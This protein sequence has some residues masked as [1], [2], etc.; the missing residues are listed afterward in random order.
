MILWYGGHL[1][2]HIEFHP[3]C[4]WSRLSTQVFFYLP[5]GILSGSRVKMRGHLIAHGTSL[6]RSAPGLNDVFRIIMTGVPESI[7]LMQLCLESIAHVLVRLTA[8]VIKCFSSQFLIPH[9]VEDGCDEVCFVHC[10]CWVCFSSRFKREWLS[11]KTIFFFFDPF[12]FTGRLPT[13]ELHGN[14][15]PLFLSLTHSAACRNIPYYFLF[16][17]NPLTFSIHL[18]FCRPPIPVFPV[19]TSRMHS[20]FYIVC[21]CHDLSLYYSSQICKFFQLVTISP[22]LF[23]CSCMHCFSYGHYCSLF[24]YWSSDSFSFWYHKLRLSHPVSSGLQW[25][26]YGRRWRQSPPGAPR[27]LTAIFYILFN[28]NILSRFVALMYFVMNEKILR[29]F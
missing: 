21:L 14:F 8:N 16:A 3:F 6:S 22:V 19:Q 12:V 18:L 26:N 5:R 10:V 20:Q 24:L 25:R 11:L 27:V 28:Y 4:P 7:V 17:V 2:R 9:I 15:F 1:G 23:L 29:A 13:M